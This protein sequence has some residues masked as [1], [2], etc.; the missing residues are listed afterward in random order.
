MADSFELIVN[1]PEREFY[2]GSV[3]MVELVTTEG[4]IGVYASGPEQ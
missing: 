4:E 2:R 1:T 3:T